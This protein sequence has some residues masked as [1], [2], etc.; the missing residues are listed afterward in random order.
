MTAPHDSPSAAQ[1][2]EAVREFLERDVLAA[3]DGRVQFHTRV[4]INVLRMVERELAVGA[5]QEA[6]HSLGLAHLGF[7]SEAELAAAIRGGAIADEQLAAV[8]A[9]VTETVRA[10]LEVA[11]PGYL[12]AESAAPPGARRS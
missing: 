7:T 9:F 4:A 11:N 12:G 2:V 6:Q 3:T 10:K 1:L 5:A 8:A